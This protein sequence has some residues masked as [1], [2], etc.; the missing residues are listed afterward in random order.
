MNV[1]EGL[2]GGNKGFFLQAHTQTS[3]LP[4]QRHCLAVWQAVLFHQKKYGEH[5]H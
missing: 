5:L 1:K 2:L 4:A 3:S